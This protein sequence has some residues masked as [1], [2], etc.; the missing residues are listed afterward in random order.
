[1][2]QGGLHQVD[3]RAPVQGVGGVGVPQPV[4]GDGEVDA[5]PVGPEGNLRT[6]L[7]ANVREVEVLPI[8]PVRTEPVGVPDREPAERPLVPAA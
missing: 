3:G 7:L 4:G 6:Y 5:G 2:T 1:M 8:E